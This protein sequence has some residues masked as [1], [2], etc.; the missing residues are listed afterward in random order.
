LRKKQGFT[1]RFVL[2]VAQKIQSGQQDAASV[3]THTCVLKTER[4]ELKS[5]FLIQFFNL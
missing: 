3:T 4:L 2:H 5:K 1:L